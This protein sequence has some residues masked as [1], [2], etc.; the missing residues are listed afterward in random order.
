VLPRFHVVSPGETLIGIARRYAVPVSDLVKQNGINPKQ[1]I[2]PGQKLKLPPGAKS[3]PGGGSKSKQLPDRVHV[4]RKG[5]TLSALALRYKVS[6]TDIVKKN[7]LNPKRPIRIG[8]R[9]TIPR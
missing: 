5:D 1:P 6:V 8:Q 9:L 4:V 3:P 2:H 7:G